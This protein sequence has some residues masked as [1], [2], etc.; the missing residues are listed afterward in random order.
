MV[1]IVRLLNRPYW[2]FYFVLLNKNAFFLIRKYPLRG[3]C[4][5][6]PEG[7]GDRIHWRAELRVTEGQT[8]VEFEIVF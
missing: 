5:A 7:R 2:D 1:K 3:Y 6:P 4:L 8:D